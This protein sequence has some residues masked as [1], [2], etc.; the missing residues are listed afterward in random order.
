MRTR[1]LGDLEQGSK[2]VCEK[3]ALGYHRKIEESL[4]TYDY[5]FKRVHGTIGFVNLV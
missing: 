1:I 5:I 3:S 4:L 2:Y